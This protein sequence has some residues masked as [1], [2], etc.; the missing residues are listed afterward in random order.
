MWESQAAFWADFSKRLREATLLVAFRRR[1][2]STVGRRRAF[3]CQSFLV[4]RRARRRREQ[5]SLPPF[6]LP[7]QLGRIEQLIT[8]PQLL[9]GLLV[10]ETRLQHPLVRRARLVVL[11]GHP[12]AVTLF[13]FQLHA[14]LKEVGVKLQRL[15]QLRQQAQ[16]LVRVT[17]LIADR[18]PHHRVV[19]LLDETT[20]VL[21]IRPRARE[22]YPLLLAVGQ[23][24]LVDEL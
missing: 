15:V 1:G 19:L 3:G 20:V 8:L 17:A 9:L 4:A 24:R 6:D 21:A 12:R 11:L 18:A 16:L 23:E 10:D 5:L 7:F 22:G 13:R 2:I 14:R